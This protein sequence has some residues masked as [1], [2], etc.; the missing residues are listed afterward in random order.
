[1]NQEGKGT[2]PEGQ[3]PPSMENREG[4]RESGRGDGFSLELGQASFMS[5]HCPSSKELSPTVCNLSQEALF[6]APTIQGGPLSCPLKQSLHSSSRLLITDCVLNIACPN[7][8]ERGRLALTP[9]SPLVTGIK[10]ESQEAWL[11][12]SRSLTSSPS[13]LLC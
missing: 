12:P 4:Q 5:G 11:I 2:L 6:P 10:Q 8:Y 1:M 7:R 9:P 3:R 13:S